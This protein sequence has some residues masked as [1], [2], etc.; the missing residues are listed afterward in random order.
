MISSKLVTL[1]S[2]TCS[3]DAT[4]CMY[5]FLGRLLRNFLTSLV[6]SMV[7]PKDADFEEISDSLPTKSSIVSVSFIFK[8]S[9][10]VI[11]VCKRAFLTLSAPR[12]RAL[13]ASQ[14][15]FAVSNSPTCRISASG[16]DWKRRAVAI[17]FF[18]GSIVS[19]STVS[20]TL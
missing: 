2:S 6:S 11:K 7:S 14:T 8:R 12:C 19:L 3:R 15:C 10:S 4:M 16:M 18:S 9:N 17:S 1:R 20:H 5:F 13:M